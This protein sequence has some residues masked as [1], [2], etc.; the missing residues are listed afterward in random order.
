MERSEAERTIIEV[1]RARRGTRHALNPIWYSNIAFGLFF[2]G[3]AVVALT[4]LSGA[5]TT[6]Y[7]VAA[8]VLTLGLVVRYYANVERALGVQSPAWDASTTIVLV[9]IVGVVLANALTDGDANAAAPLYVGAACTVALGHVLHDRIEL[10]A[11]VAIAAVATAVVALDPSE[12]GIWGN[13]GLGLALFAAGVAG[14]AR[15]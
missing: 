2:V 14:R 8:G 5:L 12:P 10:A 7:W 1:E 13:F 15:A 4:D 9:L 3:T 11:G 6:A